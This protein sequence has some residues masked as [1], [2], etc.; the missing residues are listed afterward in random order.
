MG[1]GIGDDGR[2]VSGWPIFR[3]S[4]PI[5]GCFTCCE[6]LFRQISDRL[7]L[8]ATNSQSVMHE[9]RHPKSSRGWRRS[10]QRV[11]GDG[12]R[13]RRISPLPELIHFLMKA[14]VPFR[15]IIFPELSRLVRLP[16]L[17]IRV[18]LGGWDQLVPFCNVV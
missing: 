12:D 1:C 11:F 15:R 10:H 3:L 17:L 4:N 13:Q 2:R 5:L 8:R 14:K 18:F 16:H 9:Y 7:L 6:G